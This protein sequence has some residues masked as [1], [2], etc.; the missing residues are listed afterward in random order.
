MSQKTIHL[1][2]GMFEI[3]VYLDGETYGD[4]GST[5]RYSSG[6]VDSNLKTGEREY[7]LQVEVIENLVLIHAI[8]GINIELEEYIMGISTTL[9]VINETWV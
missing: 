2:D 1:S 7:D 9:E 4:D 6:S 5:D 3:T 8:N